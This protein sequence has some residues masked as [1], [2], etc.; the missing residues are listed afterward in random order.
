LKNND[1]FGGAN[2]FYTINDV[3]KRTNL[4]PYTL[5]F[6]AKEGLLDFAERSANGTRMFKDSDFEL[7]HVI[8]CLKSTGMSIKDIKSFADWCMEGDSTI[9]NRLE[10]FKTRRKDVEA[11]IAALQETLD[12][13]K[14]KCWYYETAKE[15]GTCAVHDTINPEDIPAD[16]LKTKI[17]LTEL[18]NVK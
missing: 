18:R 14:Y 10:M 12:V 6:Y 2:M 13:V 8:E 9:E 1:F 15:A 11:Q 17:K 3:S 4:T 5:R 7:I 16:M